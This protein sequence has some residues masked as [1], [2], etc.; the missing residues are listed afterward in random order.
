MRS[1]KRDTVLWVSAVGFGV[2][3]AVVP[4]PRVSQAAD[5]SG[6]GKNEGK[7]GERCAAKSDC[8]KELSCLPAG[9]HKEC[10]EVPVRPRP[11]PPT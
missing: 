8:Q 4:G 7:A 1:R 3:L 11:V 2:A 9:D 5:V 10:T 6:K